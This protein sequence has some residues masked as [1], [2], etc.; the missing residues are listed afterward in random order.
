MCCVIQD[1]GGQKK[2]TGRLPGLDNKGDL[3]L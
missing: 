3:D 2:L 1:G